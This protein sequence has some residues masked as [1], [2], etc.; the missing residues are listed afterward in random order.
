MKSELLEIEVEYLNSRKHNQMQV[1]TGGWELATWDYLPFIL[2][3][4]LTIV[5]VVVWLIT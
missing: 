4:T 5:G 2:F 1:A 3:S